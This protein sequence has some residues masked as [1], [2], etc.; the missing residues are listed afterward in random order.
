MRNSTL[1]FPIKHQKDEI[2]DICLAMKKRGF[3]VGRWNGAGGKV[4]LGESI[5]EAARRET[6]EE[7]G[8][9][10]GNIKR[11]AELEF[12]FSEKPEWNQIVHVYFCESWQGEPNESE[13]MAPKWFKIS[14]IP[15][16]NMWP[17]DIFWLPKAIKGELIRAAFTF[18]GK[19]M[20]TKNSVETVTSLKT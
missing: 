2:T 16:P 8:I 6:T 14:E 9:I 10:P 13:E 5:E 4:N 3:G 19:D 12:T 15:F 1:L 17:D 7:I 18:D 20:I 11:I